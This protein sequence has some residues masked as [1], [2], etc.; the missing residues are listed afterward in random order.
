MRNRCRS[1]VGSDCGRNRVRSQFRCVV[2]IVI[3]F[4][5]VFVIVFIC[6][7]DRVHVVSITCVRDV[8][9][10]GFVIGSV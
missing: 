4:E 6:V 2:A 8:F 1:H 5:V 3:A 9:V 7:C 10:V